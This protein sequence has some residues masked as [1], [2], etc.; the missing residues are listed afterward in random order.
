MVV[1]CGDALTDQHRVGTGT[2]VVLDLNRAE[3]AGFRY[4]DDVIGQIGREFVVFVHVHLEVLQVARVD[5]DHLGTGLAGA[6]DLFAGVR[7][8][9]HGHAEL[10]RQ[11]EQDRLNLS[12]LVGYEVVGMA[13]PGGGVNFNQHVADVI[14][15]R[16]G[17]KYARTT[18]SSYNFEPQTDLYCF[19][20]TVYHHAQWDAM[21]KLVD[22]FIALKPD[23]PKIMY[24]WGHAYEFDIRNDWDRFEE[25]LKRLSGHDDI[26]YGTNK[27]VLLAK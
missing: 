9:Q 6:F 3:Y 5:A 20:P 16:T 8:H 25:V 7:L 14:R 12:E 17:V 19:K 10:V 4:L 27:E 21:E 13:Y 26:F 23:S 24:I 1:C 15:E 18:V 22:E 11:V 2:A